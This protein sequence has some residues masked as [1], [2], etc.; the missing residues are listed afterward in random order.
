MA[1]TLPS[2]WNVEFVQVDEREK[3]RMWEKSYVLGALVSKLGLG[4]DEMSIET[5]NQMKGGRDYWARI[6]HWWVGGC[7]FGS[8]LCIR[9]WS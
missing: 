1:R 9:L 7:C 2:T 5:Y 4:D 3:N 6:E 8:Q